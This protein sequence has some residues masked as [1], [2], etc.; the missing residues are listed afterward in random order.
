ML[1][2]A[3][4]QWAICFMLR[5]AVNWLKYILKYFKGS[6]RIFPWFQMASPL[7]NCSLIHAMRNQNFF[8][9]NIIWIRLVCYGMHT[10]I[11]DSLF[12]EMLHAENSHYYLFITW[13]YFSL[14]TLEVFV[15]F[16]HNLTNTVPQVKTRGAWLYR[17]WKKRSFI[18]IYTTF[19]HIVT[20]HLKITKYSSW[21]TPNSNV[22]NT[23]IHCFSWNPG[24]ISSKSI[25]PNKKEIIIEFNV[26]NPHHIHH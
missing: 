13:Q 8:V 21:S 5:I 6:N 25:C 12:S 23:S 9:G 19:I 10:V 14:I 22:W 17:H 15:E 16:C 4:I 1:R 2:P 11:H 20:S 3:S 26:L 7:M 24:M 18:F